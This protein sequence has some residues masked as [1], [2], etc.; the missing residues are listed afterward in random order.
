[1]ENLTNWIT[2]RIEDEWQRNGFTRYTDAL[3]DVKRYIEEQKVVLP[4]A[5]VIK[6]VCPIC[7]KDDAL[8]FDGH[9]NV[10]GRCEIDE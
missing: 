9:R 10:C 5:N 4:Q 1:M 6:S 8:R 2:K 7:K 3:I